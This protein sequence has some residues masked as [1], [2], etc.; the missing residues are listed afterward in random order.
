[1]TEFVSSLMCILLQFNTWMFFI[2]TVC[3]STG[4]T[5]I[6]F[7]CSTNAMDS[8]SDP[9]SSK[10]RF[11]VLNQAFYMFA[12]IFSQGS[13][14]LPVPIVLRIAYA[15]YYIFL[16]TMAV[17]YTSQLVALIAVSKTTLPINS[18]R[19]LAD[20]PAYKIS[21]ATGTG[22]FDFVRYAHEGALREIWEQ[23]ILKSSGKFISPDM[24]AYLDEVPYVRSEDRVILG[25]LHRLEL[26][27]SHLDMCDVAI[28]EERIFAGYMTLASYKG[29]PLVNV[30]NNR[31]IFFQN[32]AS[33]SPQGC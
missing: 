7:A 1:M 15:S 9:N 13:P 17:A 12:A 18:F 33:F 19:E 5:V 29:F 32:K 6:I 23:K 20:H 4:I 16:V 2:A 14:Q 21:I 24:E 22:L 30:F 3:M 27:I 11:S 26:V 28:V 25:S 31:Y 8:N 10:E